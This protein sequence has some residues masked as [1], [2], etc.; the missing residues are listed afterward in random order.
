[1]DIENITKLAYKKMSRRKAH[2]QREKGHI[3]YHGLRVGK[4]ALNLR[5][6]LF[7]NDDSYDDI[8]Y[9]SGLFHDI[10]KGI[11]PHGEIGSAIVQGVLKDY[12]TE[13][14]LHKIKNIIS[15]HNKRDSHKD[16][17][18]C[19]KLIQDADILDHFGTTE[20]WLN[21]L[22]NGYEENSIEESLRFYN[23][24]D[25]NNYINRVMNDLNYQESKT[26]LE[27]KLLYVETFK[28]RLEKEN[29]GEIIAL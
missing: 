26:I 21:F 13:D 6:L 28:K 18:M 27:E 23:S 4:L 17:D 20:I 29:N 11:E 24:D 15:L 8:L 22:Y 19:I 14:E 16:Y 9:V 10:G 2:L 25:Y 5:K 3:Y 12:C 7:P 1:M